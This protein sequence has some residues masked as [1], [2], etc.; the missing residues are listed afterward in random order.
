M[1]VQTNFGP[2]LIW[3]Q[4]NLRLKKRLSKRIFG[5]IIVSQK[6]KLGEKNDGPKKVL[7]S[8]NLIQIFLGDF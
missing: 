3:G 8:K 7:D 1:F 5:K 2:K 4:K 6:K